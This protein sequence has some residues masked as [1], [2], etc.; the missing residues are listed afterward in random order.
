MAGVTGSG[1]GLQEWGVAAPGVG[2]GRR[3][4]E[5]G[6]AVDSRSGEWH[7]TPG[8]GSGRRLQEWGV[9]GDSRSGEW[10]GTPGVGGG[11]D[12][13]IESI[14]KSRNVLSYE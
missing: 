8:V 3:L 4:Q 12:S 2:S 6:V 13:L 9:A 5:W 14:H 7:E 1:R 11:V 10:Q